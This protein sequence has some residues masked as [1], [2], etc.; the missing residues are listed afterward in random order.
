MRGARDGDTVVEAAVELAGLEVHGAVDVDSA[1]EAVEELDLAV[2][3][4]GVEV[5]D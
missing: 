5:R 3:V 1:R 4:G 2:A